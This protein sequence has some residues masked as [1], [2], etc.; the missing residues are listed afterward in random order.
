MEE[1]RGCRCQECNRETFFHPI[2]F[3]CILIPLLLPAS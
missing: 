2:T 3:I 1:G